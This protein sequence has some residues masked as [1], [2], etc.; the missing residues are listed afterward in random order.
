L[1]VMGGIRVKP[2][3]EGVQG[4]LVINPEDFPLGG[5]QGQHKAQKSKEAKACAKGQKKGRGV[6]NG[7]LAGLEGVA[8]G[9]KNARHTEEKQE[10]DEAHDVVEAH[11]GQ[12]QA[13]VFL[14]LAGEEDSKLREAQENA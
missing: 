12:P 6:G 11:P 5:H 13:V 4:T 10:Q 9:R 1:G 8:K 2:E 3:M 14:P 7:R